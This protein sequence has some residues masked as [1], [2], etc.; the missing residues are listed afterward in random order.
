MESSVR[1]VEGKRAIED[2]VYSGSGIWTVW[3][4]PE[5]ILCFLTMRYGEY[6]TLEL[7]PGKNKTR[8]AGIGLNERADPTADL[9]HDLND[10]LPLPDESIFEIYSNQTLEHLKKE[11]Q[12]LI[13]NEMYRVLKPG[14]KTEH[15]VP[16]YLAPASV[17]DP[18]H[19]TQYSETSFQYYCLDHSGRPFVESFSDYGIT[20][21]F[22]LDEQ[23]FEA[24][25]QGLYVKMHKPALD[26]T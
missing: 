9:F 16:Y 21:R 6:L 15:H 17:G 13:W 4:T 11:N 18:T 2:F 24:G 12:I 8:L 25:R 22:V 19:F 14:G 26:E 5:E 1:Y 10:G 7:G 3:Y 20:A 23:G